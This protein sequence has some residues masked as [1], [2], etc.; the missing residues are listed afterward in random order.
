M[1][2]ISSKLCRCAQHREH[3]L[4]ASNQQKNLKFCSYFHKQVSGHAFFEAQIRQSV[5]RYAHPYHVVKHFFKLIVKFRICNDKFVPQRK[6]M[7]HSGSGQFRPTTHPR[8]RSSIHNLFQLK[9]TLYSH[10]LTEVTSTWKERGCT[11]LTTNQWLSN[12][13]PEVSRAEERM[14]TACL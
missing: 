8:L 12:L 2:W 14:R 11:E 7:L 9:T 4:H 3:I 1:T 6:R 5:D 13:G 10:L